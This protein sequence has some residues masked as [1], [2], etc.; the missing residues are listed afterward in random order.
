MLLPM[1]TENVL[2]SRHFSWTDIESPMK[3]DF[4]FLKE[5]FGL[6]LLLVQDCMRPDQ[7]PKYERISGGFFFLLRLY[8]SSSHI[9][10]ISMQGLT[11]KLA[12]F[13]S[14]GT[15]V[16]IHNDLIVPL[17]K[18]AESKTNDD[19]PKD[20]KKLVHQLMRMSILSFEEVMQDLEKTYEKF[21]NEVLTK[22]AG[23]LSTPRVYAFRRK[24]YV[25]KSLLQLTQQ[26]LYYS[27]DFWGEEIILQQD[28]KENMGQIYF[29]LEG[30]THNFDQ[31]F[32]L[33][34]SMNEQRNNDVM[35]I[36]T[37][38]ASI[39]LP[40]T[41]IAS[42]YGM[43]FD[44]LPGLHTTTGFVGALLI[45]ATTSFVTIWFFSKK[46]WFKSM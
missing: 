13:I 38:F 2:L 29:K 6:P 46:Q 8:D 5:E 3:V 30:L 28:V 19:F 22:E 23:K 10:A 16:T 11:N 33:N 31:L 21:E 42:F 34:L 9:D 24:I 43:N 15:I 17:R 1:I 18:F 44:H 37:V 26:A 4:Q 35:K 36:L 41:F 25:M 20:P 12:I 39:M 7:L 14:E 45:M 27:K 32:A 40:L